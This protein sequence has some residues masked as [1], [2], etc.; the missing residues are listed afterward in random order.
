MKIGILLA[1]HTP[2]PLRETHG[3]F[4][5]MFARLLNGRDFEFSS[6]D[7]L[8][9]ASPSVDQADGWLIPGSLHGVYEDHA[10][11]PTLEQLIRDINYAKKPLIGVCFGHQI[12]A[13]ALGGQVEKFQGGW[14][15]GYTEY[16]LDGKTVALNAWHQDQVI[17]APSNARAL[18]SN[19]H[20]EHA[21]LAYDDH[22][23]TVQAHPEFDGPFIDGLLQDYGPGVV[24]DDLLHAA[25]NQ[26][27][28]PT[29]AA[30]LATQMADFF[31]K[32]RA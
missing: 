12:I 1:G 20:C 5:Q 18:A 22:I 14:A 26:T 17:A 6:F 3:N 24:P 16:E 32:A 23:W 11:L 28:A 4:D 25:A 2:G 10:W 30:W 27:Q 31:Q 21:V 7:L 19:A 13:K 8:D 9:G 15:V 29:D